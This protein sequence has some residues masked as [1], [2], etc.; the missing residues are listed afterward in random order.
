MAG[1]RRRL[2]GSGL[3]VRAQTRPQLRIARAKK[4]LRDAGDDRDRIAASV[5]WVRSALSDP[6]L[7]KSTAEL[8]ARRAVEYLKA[9]AQELET[10]ISIARKASRT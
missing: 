4:R 8:I 5:D 9:T 6:H 7:D 2:E 3:P 1:T 10:A